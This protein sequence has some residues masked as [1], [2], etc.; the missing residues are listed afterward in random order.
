MLP[1]SFFHPGWGSKTE[2]PLLYSLRA[3]DSARWLLYVI[4]KRENMKCIL[5]GSINLWLAG[6][7]FFVFG[8]VLFSQPLEMTVCS[9]S[10]QDKNAEEKLDLL[11]QIGT[12][13]IQTYIFWNKVEKERGVMDWSEYDADVVLLKKHGLQWVPF[14]IAGP[15]YVTPEFVRRDPE[16]AMLR[17]LEHGR[18]SAIPSLWSPR[19]RDYVRAYLRTFAEHY[20]PQGILESINLGIT[21]DYGEAIYSVIG[22]W[23]GEYHSHGGFWCGDALALADFRRAMKELYAG[24]IG[25]LNGAWKSRYGSFEEVTPFLPG[26]APSVRARLE[27][28]RWYRDSMTNYAEFWLSAAREFFP[29]TEVYLCTGGDMAPEHGS[30]FSAQAKIAARYGAG[31]R[32]TNEASSFP[33][34]VA[35]TRLVGSA[36][37]FYGAYFGHEP[38]SAVTPVGMLGRLFNAVSSGARQLFLYN[39][40]ELIAEREGKPAIGDGGI[41]HLKYKD[42]QKVAAPVIDVGLLYPTSSSTHA[43]NDYGTFRDLAAEIRRAVDYDFVDERLI[44]D[45]A[46]KNIPILIIIGAD[47]LED[48]TV[49]KITDWV[50]GGGVLFVLGS[51]PADWDGA[52]AQFDRAIGLTPDSDEIQGITELAID[53]PQRLPSIA[54]LQATFIARAFTA[55][56]SDA[57]PLLSMRYTDKGKV[58]WRRDFGRGRVYAYFGPLDLRQKEESWMVARNLPFLFFK[59]GVSDAVRDGKLKGAPASLNF[60]V[61]DVYLVE[62]QEGLRALNMGDATKKI[63][64]P[65]G[66]VEIPGRSFIKMRKPF[67]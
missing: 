50:S 51:R 47:I 46:L 12:T 19:L 29:E 35:L 60:G 62:T 32:I 23:P 38:A 67:Q 53:S 1:P 6:L 24:D 15:W 37:R 7:S 61:R 66:G 2:D 63:A 18:E 8:A 16:I 13:S 33:Q 44:Q 39:T 17:C 9:V 31:I 10:H 28:L 40:P 64:Y 14:I 20:L 26:E 22:N 43:F 57:E 59:D 27:M 55:L 41:Y 30:D 49:Q 54:A 65:G 5:V 45:G 56:A 11:K 3:L 34:N 42:W 36:C 52:T 21:G 25:A 58:A 48:L 4:S